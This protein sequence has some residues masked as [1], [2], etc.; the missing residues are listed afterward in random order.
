MS[1]QK[2]EVPFLKPILQR[3]NPKNY[4]GAQAVAVFVLFMY[5]M[6]DQLPPHKYNLWSQRVLEEIGPSTDLF[7]I[8]SLTV[9]WL[10]SRHSLAGA[11]DRVRQSMERI[12]DLCEQ[13]SALNPYQLSK[14]ADDAIALVKSD[15][16]AN[17]MADWIQPLI[18]AATWARML[19]LIF[20][21]A[22]DLTEAL[23]NAW[24]ITI[25]IDPALPGEV[26]SNRYTYEPAFAPPELPDWVITEKGVP[27]R[28]ESFGIPLADNVL[29]I[30][31]EMNEKTH[32]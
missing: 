23:D 31:I 24:R 11:P 14:A 30:I 8:L 2:E 19:R 26:I 5:R 25:A 7:K 13:G 9:K 32:A 29:S 12:M 16:P 6:V 10:L 27:G 4:F 1:I 21:T 20:L 15:L 18:L 3:V 28:A 17:I 22:Q